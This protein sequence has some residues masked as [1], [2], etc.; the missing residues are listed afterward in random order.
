MNRLFLFISLFCGLSAIA[1]ETPYQVFEVDSAAEPRGGQAYLSTFMAANLRKPM[2]IEATGTGGR[3]M[4]T[5]VVET[6]GRLSNPKVIQGFQPDCDKE[7]LRVFRLYNAWKP[8]QK[9]GKAV[10]QQ[11]TVP[12]TFARNEP[13]LYINGA[14]VTYYDS[15]QKPVKDSTQALYKQINP[16]DSLGL[17]AGDVVVYRLKGSSWKEYSRLALRHKEHAYKSSDGKDVQLIGYQNA[18]LQWEGQLIAVDEAGDLREQMYYENGKRIGT[19]LTYYPNGIVDEKSEEFEDRF[20]NTSWH[21]NGQIH[22]VRTSY[23]PVSPNPPRPDQI[24]GMWDKDGN[25]LVKNGSGKAVH[26]TNV[27][28]RVSLN[29]TLFTEQGAYE[30]GLKQGTWIGN[31]ADKSFF[32]EEYYEKGICQ[33]GKSCIGNADTVR[34]TTPEKMP[35]FKGGMTGLGQFLSENLQYPVSAQRAGVQGK[36]FVSFVVCE[37]GTLCDYEILK[38]IR[39]DVNEE[40]MRVVKKMSGKWQP[41]T[42]R[43]Q[44]VRVKY[45]LPINFSLY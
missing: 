4:L 24:A 37:D 27:K 15:E 25:Q 45:N 11:I 22:Y 35:E 13:F 42:Q 34:Y 39:P 26:Q 32:Y 20:V 36:V 33:G 7:A 16:L 9:N 17:P 6:D 8:A 29:E 14:K 5:G 1:Q 41:G 18:I 31:Y 10:R 12:I 2:P 28:S 43:G 30:N 21:P 3:V 40:A 23:K 38:G 44:N 19:A